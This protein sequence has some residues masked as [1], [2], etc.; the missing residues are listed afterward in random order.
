[1]EAYQVQ[2]F[3]PTWDEFKYFNNYIE[4]IESKGAHYAG[5]AKVFNLLLFNFYLEFVFLFWIFTNVVIYHFNR[6]F[7]PMSG[8]LED[9]TLIT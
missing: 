3:Y 1:M 6:L 2:V 7:H 9:V 8:N 5:I 4:H